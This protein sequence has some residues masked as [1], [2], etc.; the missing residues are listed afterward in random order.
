MDVDDCKG[1][2]STPLDTTVVVLGGII[3]GGG[4]SPPPCAVPSD[5][6]VLAGS[7]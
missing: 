7:T 4:V 1:A 5:P 6:A 3:G 2:V